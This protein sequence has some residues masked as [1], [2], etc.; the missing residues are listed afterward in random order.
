MN[1]KLAAA[2]DAGMVEL[3]EGDWL[4]PAVDAILA[5]GGDQQ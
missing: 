1:P 3:F 4:E 2:C 5:L